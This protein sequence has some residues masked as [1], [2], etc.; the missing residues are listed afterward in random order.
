MISTQTA[1]AALVPEADCILGLVA[2][3]GGDARTEGVLPAHITLV[4]PFIPME[5]VSEAELRRLRE[6]FAAQPAFGGELVVGWFGRE[7]LL[8][9]P[10]DPAPLIQLTQAVVDAWP[11][12]PYYG[13]AYSEIEPHVTLAYGDE[14]SLSPIAERVEGIG[15]VPFSVSSI[16]L[17]E[18]PKMQVCYTFGLSADVF[19]SA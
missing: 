6:F 11:E 10:A 17:C 9:V 15:A 5:L 13:G 16:T 18:G 3:M 14:A 8:L 2:S 7:V 19:I 12:Y 4:F 1:L